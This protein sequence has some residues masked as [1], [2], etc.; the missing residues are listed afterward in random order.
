MDFPVNFAGFL[1]TPF[2]QNTSGFIYL[3]IYTLFNVDKL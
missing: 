2:L 1:R 3:F